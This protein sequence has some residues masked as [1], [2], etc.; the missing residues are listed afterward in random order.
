MPLYRYCISPISAFATPPRSDTWYGHLLWAAMETGG[1]ELVE[2]LI[3]DFCGSTPP[4]LL[5]SAFPSGMLPMPVLPPISRQL[6]RDKFIAGGDGDQLFEMLSL[7]KKFIKQKF[8]TEE[9]WHKHR[10][11]MS[12]TALFNEFHQAP[13]QFSVDGHVTQHYQSH[14]S[15]NRRTDMV[16][17]E[18]GLHFSESVF[19]PK[20]A[21]LDMYVATED[22]DQFEALLKHVAFSGFGA[23]SSSGKGY[24]TWQ[25]DTSPPVETLVGDGPY[26]MSLSV[27]SCQDMREVSGYYNS[28][29]K[30]GRAWNG[31]GENNPFKKPFLALTEGSVFS[32]LPNSGFTLR[33]IHS[34]P[35]IVQVAWP[36]TIP[37]SL[38][39]EA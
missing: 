3:S 20:G 23:D 15:I 13:E 35:K 32:Q 19:Y 28:F 7:Y 26:R 11:N 37:L 21:K 8:I 33:N 38:E 5:S 1:E 18:G 30:R 9:T 36:L 34:N 4:F 14:N 39:E 10:T 12:Q 24:F 29:I 25:R 27:L 2:K 6:F 22:Q 16:L 17:E 31:Y